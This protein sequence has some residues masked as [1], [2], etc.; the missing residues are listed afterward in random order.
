MALL[1]F[2]LGAAYARKFLE[3]RATLA[4]NQ[5]TSI[6]QH[7]REIHENIE[8]WNRKPLLQR[9]YADFYRE[10]AARV[11]PSVPG[12]I[13]ELGSGMGNI[14]ERLPNCITTDVFPNPWLDAV[15]NAYS[16]SFRDSSVG[17][18]ILFDVWHHLEFPGT[19]LRE[20]Y[21]VL[22]PEGRLIVFDPA[23]GLFGRMVFGM[24]HHEPLALRDRIAWYAPAS[25]SAEAH[26]YYAAQGNASRIFGGH[27]FRDRLEDWRVLEIRYFSALSYLASGGL[28]GPQFYPEALLP[29]LQGIDRML[30]RFPLLAS[31]MLVVLAK[32]P[33]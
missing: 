13:V 12:T 5:M 33:K 17:H 2:L 18:L 22:R 1:S 10:I 6:E 28:R 7:N 15:E 16:L 9:I 23:M 14:K 19:A 26:R 21:R 27:E 32:G 20:F 11:N 24:F 29:V 30:S 31:R 25:F 4:M 8:Y 3:A